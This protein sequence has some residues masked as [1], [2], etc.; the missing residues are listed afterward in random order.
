MTG[1]GRLNLHWS[2]AGRDYLRKK[3]RMALDEPREQKG[4]KES[5]WD[6]PNAGFYDAEGRAPG[7]Q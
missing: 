2:D 5:L 1:N 4:A 6:W 7:S 3:V